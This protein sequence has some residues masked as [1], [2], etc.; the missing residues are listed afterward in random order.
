MV[1]DSTVGRYRGSGRHFLPLGATKL[2]CASC[3]KL[4]RGPG[5]PALCP[6]C[7]KAS[8]SISVLRRKEGYGA[9][10]IHCVVHEVQ[11]L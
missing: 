2:V 5:S 3:G 6:D 10:G 7:H 4:W 9:K 1:F 11:N 8:F